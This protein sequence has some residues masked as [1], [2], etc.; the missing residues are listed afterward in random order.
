LAGFPDE[1]ADRQV[2]KGTLAV[3]LGKENASLLAIGFIG[4]SIIS[5][6]Y[7][8]YAPD[9]QALFPFASLYPDV[10]YLAIFHGLIFI[11]ALVR[12]RNKTKKPVRIDGLLILGLS[13]ILW[14]ALVPFLQLWGQ[15][16]T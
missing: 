8:K 1:K 16:T 9:V 10:F 7:F 3:R 12:Y 14:F 4:L 2:G 5:L 6:L 13:Y 15:V 11:H